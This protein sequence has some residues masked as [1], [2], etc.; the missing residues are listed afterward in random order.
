MD[1][2]AA[3]AMLADRL[4][5][6]GDDAAVIGEQLLTIDMLHAETDFPAGVSEYTV[7]WRTVGAS[8]SD[9]AAMGGQ[10]TAAVAVYG[11]PGFEPDPL[12]A[13]V[14]GALDVCA[15]V[16]AKY[17][18]GDL[19]HHDEPTTVAA[20]LGSTATTDGPI[21]RDGAR[22]GDRVCVTG[23]LGRSAAAL[24][25]FDGGESERANDLFRFSPRV[26]AGQTLAAHATAMIDSSDGLARS[27]HQVADAS[28]C[29]VDLVS[30]RLPVDPAVD[31][32]AQD[33]TQRREFGLFFG[34]DFELVCTVP[35]E[36]VA[37]L[38]ADCPVAVTDIG[39]VTDVG[40]TIDGEVLPDRGYDHG[41]G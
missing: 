19:D 39:T 34:E 20:V 16:D 10:P 35:P 4:S 1:E 8:L 31:T 12:E 25:L 6:A 30:D 7:G 13:F 23:T 15:A 29:G 38:K 28:G 21:R 5:A 17:V 14:E 33:D 9:I 18:G 36:Q 2:R 41:A 27:V 22:P 40:V 26:A 24:A 3:L 32:V 37:T 11:R